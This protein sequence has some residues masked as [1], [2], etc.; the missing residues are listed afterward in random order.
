[1]SNS[2]EENKFPSGKKVGR[3]KNSRNRSKVISAQL[4]FDDAA[5]LASKTLIDIMQNNV[6]QLNLKD[7]KDVPM[8][9]RL[10][11][12]KIV[13]DKAIANEKEKIGEVKEDTTAEKTDSAPKV[14][15]KAFK[16]V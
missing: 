11:A 4:S 9:L 6:D 8:S 12:A 2:N 15:S 14:V 7:D 1:M 10:Q 16:S 13:I 3:P 5:P